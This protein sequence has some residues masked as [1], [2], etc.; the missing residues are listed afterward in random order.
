LVLTFALALTLALSS[1]GSG[2]VCCCTAAHELGSVACGTLLALQL[3]GR[4]LVCL[5]LLFCG[6]LL[7]LRGFLSILRGLLGILL[8][9][10]CVLLG[11]LLELLICL[12]LLLLLLLC[13]FC[14][15]LR[16][17]SL[18]ILSEDR[19]SYLLL[20]LSRLQLG[21]LLL[22]LLLSILLRLFLGG[23]RESVRTWGGYA[24]F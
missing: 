2:L 14:D 10:L 12:F 3:L 16:C 8:G 9:L 18:C 5:L 17:V 1:C 19:N 15:R 4:L 6:L 23:L 21:L 11:L 13:L 20:L 24:A 7:F 22:H